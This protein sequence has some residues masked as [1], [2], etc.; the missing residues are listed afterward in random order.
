MADTRSDSEGHMKDL[1]EQIQSLQREKDELS[2]QL[3]NMQQNQVG[4]K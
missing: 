1:Q 2:E 4:N 3:K